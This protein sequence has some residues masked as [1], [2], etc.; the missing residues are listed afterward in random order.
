VLVSS[1]TLSRTPEGSARDL[2]V[3]PNYLPEY[4]ALLSLVYG[5]MKFED[6]GR[7]RAFLPESPAIVGLG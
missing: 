4:S 2:V 5:G 1:E 3:G 6:V 7:S